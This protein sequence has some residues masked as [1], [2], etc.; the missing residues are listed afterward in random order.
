MVV[1]FRV[2]KAPITY[3]STVFSCAFFITVML[4]ASAIIFPYLIGGLT[5]NFFTPYE[6]RAERPLVYANPDME[7]SLTGTDT[8]IYFVLD[9]S[10]DVL[11]SITRIPVIQLPQ[12]RDDRFLKFSA[13]FPLRENEVVSNVRLTFTFVANFTNMDRAFTSYVE[14][15][16]ST[17]LPACALNIFGSMSFNQELALNNNRR[18]EVPLSDE[19]IQFT[20]TRAVPVNSS[21]P[22]VGGEPVFL[23]RNDVWTFGQCNLFEVHFSMRIPII[24]TYQEREG[25]YSF[26]D[27]WTT[28]VSIAVPLFLIIW[29]ALESFFESGM[30][31]IMKDIEAEYNTEKIPKFNR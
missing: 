8:D 15:D 19:Y 18:T 23:N 20:R 21:N 25:W 4:Y 10:S 3:S 24:K 11:S 27:G 7:Y 16:E 9:N 6:V 17:F 31:P 12:Q 14:I 22:L 2:G 30:I 26:L 1:I 13:Y 29:L 28:Y 5:L